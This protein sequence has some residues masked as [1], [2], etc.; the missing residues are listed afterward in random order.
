MLF[1]EAEQNLPSHDLLTYF[2][3]LFVT[4]N[5][6]YSLLVPFHKELGEG[7]YLDVSVNVVGNN[8]AGIAWEG[9]L[10]LPAE[11]NLVALHFCLIRIRMY[12]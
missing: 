1:Q 12:I 8:L 6:Y 2:L 10:S 4:V 9:D 5:L 3:A 7:E 11:I